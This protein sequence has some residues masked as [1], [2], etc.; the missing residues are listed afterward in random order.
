[1]INATRFTKASPLALSLLMAVPAIAQTT[2]T[3]NGAI[4][5][6]WQTS[7]NWSPSQPAF[8]TTVNGRLNVNNGTNN[9][10]IYTA[11]EGSTIFAGGAVRGLVIGSG[12]NGSMSITGGSF[13]TVGSTTG[14][15][16]G[17]GGATGSLSV[18]GGSY[19][20][21]APLALSLTGSG[22]GTLTVSGSGA[23]TVGGALVLGSGS[24]TATSTV[25]LNGGTLTAN[26]VS[27][28]SA[29]TKTFNFNGGTLKV[30]GGSFS[31]SGLTTAN[32]RDGGARFDTN[33]HN[34]TI[35]QALVHSALDGDAARDGGLTKDGAGTLT[36]GG[37]NT[38]T[39]NTLINVGTLSLADNAQ[40]AFAYIG[41]G[42]NTISGAG[43]LVLNGDFSFDLTGAADGTYSIISSDLLSRTSIGGTFTVAGWTESNS[44]WTSADGLASFS[45]LSGQ[46]IV[47]SI[48][49]PAI[50]TLLAG[51]GG[52]AIAG[53]RRRRRW[54]M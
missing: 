37:V 16:I 18:S 34:T 26:N 21:S 20:T 41:G 36:L 9:T 51:L 43:S 7:T 29:G 28:G 6:S 46:L 42:F 52:V 22:S 40:L 24:G 35:A 50:A 53:L 12:T 39:G 13:S 54:T 48:P 14:D 49:E 1:M 45:E 47:S 31:L 4:D 44:V 10:L 5:T 23:V 2:Y 30:G 32:V 27:A 17:N 8:N 11:S 15:I 19:T 3:W 38:F 25:N 33:G